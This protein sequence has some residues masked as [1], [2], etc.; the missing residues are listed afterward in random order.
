MRSRYLHR[1]FRRLASLSDKW[2]INESTK[3]KILWF[4][5]FP[6]TLFSLFE[7]KRR[8]FS[9]H[10]TRK[11][12][13]RAPRLIYFRPPSLP[14]RA[15]ACLP[16]FVPFSLLSLLFGLYYIGRVPSIPLRQKEFMNE[17][18]SPRDVSGTAGG[19]PTSCLSPTS[20]SSNNR[21][22]RSTGFVCCA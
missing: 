15:Y 19:S 2:T 17:E 4:S 20:S 7:A 18:R 1:S 8:A 22:I 5:F 12:Y 9:R 6:S 11:V 13:A 10:T 21:R 16:A 3:V 14:P